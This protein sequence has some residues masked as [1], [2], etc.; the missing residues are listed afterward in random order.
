MVKAARLVS[1]VLCVLV[2]VG[3]GG[4]SAQEIEAAVE[5]TVTARGVTDAASDGAAE[6]EPGEAPAATALPTIVERPTPK[7]TSV[8]TAAPTPPAS[9]TMPDLVCV[10]LQAAQDILQEVTGDFFIDSYDAS[11]ENRFQI[12]DSNWVVT[13]QDPAAGQPLTSDPRI[14]AVK[15]DEF[16]CDS[17]TAAADPSPVS[18]TVDTDLT[19][20]CR[21]STGPAGAPWADILSA[22]A[23]FAGSELSVTIQIAGDPR[24]AGEFDDPFWAIYVGPASSTFA[25][26]YQIAAFHYE[27]GDVFQFFDFESPSATPDAIVGVIDGTMIKMEVNRD[28]LPRL[29]G[30]D[31]YA[32][33]ASES[34]LGEFDED[35]CGGT[36]ENMSKMTLG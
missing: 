36:L 8:P 18:P 21:S 9:P 28:R 13:E 5:A 30:A 2:F 27:A 34:G 3:C 26:G 4:Q 35:T 33:V 6:V 7:A 16:D 23:T 24:N 31:V 25:G 10:D 17:S 29:N 14:G 19:W 32:V 15:D 20:Q 11:G 22:E 12:N 1:A